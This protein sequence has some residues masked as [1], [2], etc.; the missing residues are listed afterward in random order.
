MNDLSRLSLVQERTVRSLLKIHEDVMHDHLIHPFIGFILNLNV[1]V[2]NAIEHGQEF[3]LRVKVTAK[4]VI[5][6]DV[7]Y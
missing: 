3:I 2:A 4:T 1:F 6:L 7:G 5:L